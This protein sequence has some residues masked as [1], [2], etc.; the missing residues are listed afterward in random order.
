MGF[1]DEA[2]SPATALGGV[3]HLQAES[4]GEVPGSSGSQR[5]SKLPGM[6]KT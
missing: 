1:V 5:K 2:T 6:K 3:P 4:P